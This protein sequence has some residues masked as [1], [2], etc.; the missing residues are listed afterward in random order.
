MQ[1]SVDKNQARLIAH[2]ISSFGHAL[3]IADR[4]DVESILDRVE[5]FA[6]FEKL[7]FCVNF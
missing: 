6:I 7:G 1:Q 3:Q 4:I 2:N 5:H